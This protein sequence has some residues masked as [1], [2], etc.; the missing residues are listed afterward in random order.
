MDADLAFCLGQFIDDQMQLIDDR[1]EEI[2]KEEIVE[3]QKLEKEKIIYNQKKPPPKNKGSHHED[4][5]LVDQFIEELRDNEKTNNTKT[6]IDNPSCIDTLRAEIST[7]VNAS[8]KYISR[9]RNLAKPLP[10]TTKF[11][12]ACSEAIDNFNQTQVFED[13]FKALGTILE[14]T[15]SSN[16]VQNV[17][18]WW[19]D[20]YGSTIADINRRNQ[21][22]NQAITEDGFAT[23]SHT[24]RIVDNA[25]K[26]IDARTVISV[27]PPKL[28]I[29]RKFVRRLL[30]I[31]EEKREKTDANELI[32]Q[33]NN[34]DI[35]QI[36]DYAKRW[37]AKRDEIRNQ[38]EEENPCM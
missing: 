2:K 3:R 16:V 27:Q 15:D 20:V 38:K 31:D 18:K 5:A 1:L 9:L 13:N 24:S 19:K 10:N 7:K 11:V 6:I 32:D 37:L 36:I 23:V 8:A 22:I 28:D 30:S 29:I 25:K 4:K 35:E 34:S 14:Q 17:Q 33:L 21:K 12:Q 26:L